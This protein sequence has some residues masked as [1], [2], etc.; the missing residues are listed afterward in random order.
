LRSSTRIFFFLA[1]ATYFTRWP[2]VFLSAGKLGLLQWGSH[3]T[4]RSAGGSRAQASRL[5]YGQRGAFPMKRLKFPAGM[6]LCLL[7]TTSGLR[8]APPTLTN[9]TPRGAERGKT[10]EIVVSGTNLTPQTRLLVPFKATQAVVP[11]AKPNPAQVRFQLTVDASVPFGIYPV[12]VATDEGVS[13]LQ[14][15]SVEAFPNVNEVKGNNTFEKAQKVPFPAVI[16]GQCAGGEVGFFRFPARKDQQVVIET[17]SARLGSGVLPH[18]RVTDARQRFIAADDSQALQGDARVVFKAPEEGE[19][20]V[21]MSDSRYRA[22]P[23]PHYR[24]AI[25]E[26]DVIEEVFPL[27]G[28]RG[29]TVT[30]RLRGG[31][32]GQ[33]QR[34]QRLVDDAATP[35][36]ML[37]TLEGIGRPGML[38]PRIAVGELPEKVWFKPEGKDPK[39]FDLLSPV[40]INGRLERKGDSDRFQFPVEPGQRYRIAVQAESL[41]SYL[42]GVLRISDQTG[43][44]LALVDDVDVPPTA[45]GQPPTKAA[46]PSLD[47]TVPAGTSLLV[48]ELWDQR[49][50][51]GTNFGYRLA[52]EPA[53]AD[54]EIRQPVSEI[55]VPRGGA[56]LLAVPIVRRGYVGPLELT[57]PNLPPFLAVQGGHV[58]A[59]APQGLLTLTAAA[60]APPLTEPLAL[61]I[62]GKG[63]DGGKELRRRAVQHLVVSREANPA[64][65]TMM[66]SSFAV[67]LGAREPFALQG[68]V[69]LEAVK[70]Y[71]TMVPVM[72]QRSDPKLPTIEVTAD[73]STAGP[74]G[75]PAANPLGVKPVGAGAEAANVNLTLTPTLNA[76]EGTLDF[77]IQGKTKVNNADRIVASAAVALTLRGPFAV[78]APP[79]PLLLT[80]GQPATLTVRLNR[81]AV[82][83]EAVTWKLEGLPAGVT[84]AMPPRAVPA[85]AREF[86]I[87][88][89]VAPKVAAAMAN[90][91]LTCSTT[92]GGMA[93]NHPAVTIASQLK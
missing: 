1:I 56:A 80:T 89:K 65:C 90:L 6:M 43:K 61:R 10:M 27:G 5:Y 78:E 18:L 60:D 4:V 87:E 17:L 63:S 40:T 34:V 41:G 46:D 64:T 66:L 9:L 79:G 7:A 32:L 44:Q 13:A 67:G 50:R 20:V 22:A 93:Y 26:Y 16:N 25:G 57:I 59:N 3:H 75:Q 49:K 62:E 11:D 92:I 51:G 35:G 2:A 24:L 85:D 39:A 47:F 84:L 81:Q 73:L 76:P 53:V 54:Y 36:S 74:Q 52:V 14:F 37:L 77:V 58:P 33:E 12:R 91:T 29:E 23:P 31:T 45:P 55:N 86:Q 82:F 68:P 70:G 28:R 38:P 30:F 48:L 21:E 71:P 83:K 19:Y 69:T 15:F 8:A 72:I 88:L 42:D